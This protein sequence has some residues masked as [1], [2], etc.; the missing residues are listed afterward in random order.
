MRNYPKTPVSLSLFSDK[1]STFVSMKHELSIAIPTY[2]GICVELVRSLYLQAEAVEGLTYEVIVADD[3]STL[4]QCIEAN[5]AINALP[6]CRYITRGNNQGR[7]AIRNFLAREARY[8]WLLFLD[9]DMTIRRDDF[10]NRYLQSP[11]KEVI[12]GGYVV[13]NG[14]ASN[15]RYCYEK[16]AEPNHTAEQRSKSPYRDFHTANF[17]IRRDLMLSH[18]FDERFRHYGYEDVLLGKQLRKA[19]ISIEHI[20]NP[21]GFDTFEDNPHF[22]SKTE[23]GLRTLY[24]FREELRGYNTLLTLAN[25]IHLSIAKAAIRLGHRLFGPLGRRLLCSS[26]PN[27][28][29]FKLY[30]LGY[31]LSLTHNK[32]Q[33]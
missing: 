24:E 13:G 31:F 2:N 20:D 27:L 15:L 5:R 6:H 9:C 12:Y 11:A 7:A 22:V 19:S 26:H 1:S 10:L 28:T 32:T 25:G 17:L 21:V 16:S 8:E 33:L 14:P 3:G 30:K 4:P 29:I 18:P 23:E